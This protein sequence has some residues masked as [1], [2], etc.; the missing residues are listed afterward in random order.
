MKLQHLLVLLLAGL[1]ACKAKEKKQDLQIE[2]NP[3]DTVQV[4]EAPKPPPPPVVKEIDMGV[5]LDDRYF[6]VVDTYTV[7]E[8]AESWNREYQKQGYKSAVIMRN[9]DGYYHLAV[10]S[11]NDFD[12][13]QKALKVLREEKDFDNAWIMV[14]GK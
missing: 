5:K 10:Q 4:V 9:E 1:I 3:Q 8:F 13:A 11:F 14:I 2:V 12:L 6:L 7:K